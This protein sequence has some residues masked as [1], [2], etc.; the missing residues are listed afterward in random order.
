MFEKIMSKLRSGGL[1]LKVGRQRGQ[2]LVE[3]AIIAPILIFFLIGI[4][5][6]GYALRNYVVLTNVNREITRFGVRPGYVDFS[7][8]DQIAT[9]YQRV[10][11]Y[12]LTA[13]ADQYDLSF[14][15]TGNATLIVSH[16]VI[17]T[18]LPCE[19]IQS[20]PDRCDCDAFVENPNYSNQ[21][22]LDD[23]IIHPGLPG[24]SYQAQRFGPLVTETGTKTTRIDFDDLVYNELVPQNNKLNC[25]LIKKGG[26]PSAN[27]ML[28]TEIF[29]D[30]AQLFGFPFI[31]NPFSDP[32]PLY[33]H[34]AMRLTSSRSTDDVNMVGPVCIAH[35]ITFGPSVLD[36]FDNPTVGQNIDAYEGDAPGDFG[37]LAWN[38][39]E[40]DANY[41]EAELRN[42]RMSMNDFTNM[43]NPDDHS[44]S[45]GDD[46]A[47]KT[48]VANSDEID[49]QMQLLV[50]QVI[51]VPVYSQNVG[52]GAGSYY[53][54]EHF[55]RV[56]IDQ[57]CLPRNGSTCDGASSK[58]IKATFLG[59]DDEACSNIVISP[60][61]GN[62]PPVARDDTI[63]VGRNTNI[64]IDVLANDSDTDG[65]T[66]VVTNVDEI[67]QPFKE[68]VQVSNGGSNVT[69][70]SGNQTGT[71][72]FEY[73]IS[74]GNGGEA[75]A[76]VTIE[77][78][79][80]PPTSTPT[81]V[82][83]TSTP[84][85]V[86]P[87]N[88][89]VPPPTNTPVPP[90]NTPIPPTNTPTPVPPTSTPTPVP[91]TNTPTPVPPTNTPVP[92]T[93]T[94]T[95]TPTT[96]AAH[97]F[98]DNSWSGGS[99]WSGGWSREGRY[100]LEQQSGSDRYAV[101]RGD[102]NGV[103]RRT[104]NMTGVSQARLSFCWVADSFETGDNA[105]VY[106]YDGVG[107]SSGWHE[108]LR[109][110]QNGNGCENI[111]LSSYSM[112]NN[113][114]IGISAYFNSRYD[115]FYIDDIVITGIR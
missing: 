53:H 69:Y 114:Q 43:N 94:P 40:Q 85:T 14:E 15:N 27:N 11:D 98:D 93:N 21:Y 72:V 108:V 52:S 10:R 109:V 57:V 4:F 89:P 107:G 77:V 41:V 68:T 51:L 49:N 86:P 74:D 3:V 24:M 101:V 110:N 37:W 31:S 26:V 97:N 79:S 71:F 78:T 23:L 39:E 13:L 56:R 6:V 30:Q 62:S 66:L 82:P 87:T 90:T 35:P 60:G 65:D 67:T 36:D 88:T 29:L 32:V 17:D 92:P 59:Y 112:V 103:L 28:V 58:Q 50:G 54:V 84:T 38:P 102:S 5:E 76:R 25:E 99:G 33:S 70:L 1:S 111:S 22:K 104:V 18:A 44:L 61:G 106:I 9:D 16:V 80:T 7:T 96:I 73:T 2:S 95:P 105:R 19:D 83:P 100:G 12:A 8:R 34:T 91:P 115:Y 113:F 75:K 45:I 48:G 55:A 20:R 47:V 46:V 81:T 63:I 64:T 42:P